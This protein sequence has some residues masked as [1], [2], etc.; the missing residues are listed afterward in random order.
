MSEESGIKLGGAPLNMAA[1][2]PAP[3]AT[4]EPKEQPTS[5]PNFKNDVPP[6]AEPAMEEFV[7]DEAE[8]PPEPVVPPEPTEPKVV[9]EQKPEVAAP[10]AEEPAP[11]KGVESSVKSEDEKEVPVKKAATIPT[12]VSFAEPKKKEAV[13]ADEGELRRE[14]AGLFQEP[15]TR[16]KP[17][18]DDE[19]PDK[20]FN[21]AITGTQ[22]DIDNILSKYKTDADLRRAVNVPGSFESSMGEVGTHGWASSLYQA[23]MRDTLK[24][25]EVYKKFEKNP[26]LVRDFFTHGMNYTSDN[27]TV[28]TG[29]KARIAVMARMRGLQK[30]NLLNSGF[31]IVLRAPQMAELQE[32]ASSVEIEASEFGREL[33]N[34]FG[35]CTDVFIKS[36]FIELLS[37]YN[38]IVDSNFAD[39]NKKGALSENISIFDY[40]VIMWALVSLMYRKGLHTKIVCAHCK[41]VTADALVDVLSAKWLNNDLYTE[42]VINYWS[43]KTDEQGRPLVRT[44]KDLKNYRENIVGHTKRLVQEYNGTKIALVIKDPTME[45]FLTVGEELITNL[46]KT[47]HGPTRLRED[48]LKLKSVIHLFQMFAPWISAIEFLDDQD[49]V[50]FSTTEIAAIMDVLDVSVQQ[51]SKLI[52]A[53]GEYSSEARLNHIGTFSIECPECHSKPETGLDNFFPLDVETIFFALSCRP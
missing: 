31:Y 24:Q 6:D 23:Y 45:R 11:M 38:M 2:T 46:N 25:S 9:E 41:T 32:F 12:S 8:L 20:L 51:N 15:A 7:N 42:E 18:D 30:V 4:E 35:L 26:E 10:V 14:F 48:Q 37:D 50:T 44:A 1:P 27:P 47:L 43:T 29:K 49:K 13:D 19:G 28:L 39:I 53:I 36:K 16:R 40:D 52:S 17:D 21:A 22:E 5:V 34:H 33:G 3:A